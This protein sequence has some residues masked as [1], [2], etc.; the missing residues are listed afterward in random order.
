MN[1]KALYNN[2]QHDINLHEAIARREH[3]HPQMPIDLNERLMARVEMHPSHPSVTFRWMWP[4]VAAC[5]VAALV[6]GHLQFRKQ[7]ETLP[8]LSTVGAPVVYASTTDTTYKSPVLVDEFI[9]KLA[10]YNGIE[11][12]ML[13]GASTTD[14]DIN[15]YIYVFPNQKRVDVFARLLQVACWYSNDSPGYQLHLSQEMFL[16]ELNDMHEGRHHMW[17]AEKI[18]SDTFLYGVNAPIGTTFSNTSYRDFRD[19]HAPFN[20]KYL[21]YNL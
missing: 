9:A 8:S 6:I 18:G 5:I 15:S 19:K 1:D 10:S 2:R 21:Y 4:S 17:L 13:D 11:Q 7:G 20:K 3:K 16:F 14:A 12:E